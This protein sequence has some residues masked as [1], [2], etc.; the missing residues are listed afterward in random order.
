LEEVSKSLS[1]LFGVRWVPADVRR[2]ALKPIGDED[3]IPMVLAGGS[4]DISS[5]DGL[6]EIAEDIINVKDSLGGSGW[7]CDVY[8]SSC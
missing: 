5:L 2:L 3:L 6:R 7:A 8:L 1:L 4:Q